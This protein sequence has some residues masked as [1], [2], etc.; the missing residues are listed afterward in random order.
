[1]RSTE[2]LPRELDCVVVGGGAA[3]LSAAVN[4]GRMRR[5]VL[6]VDERD[7]L[8]W[9]H[10]AHNYLG[11]P[12][13]IPA[14]EI[15]RLGWRHAARYGVELL[16][17]HVA[18]AAREGDRF[19]LRIQRLPEGEALGGGPGPSIPRDAEMTR[20]FGEVPKG[21][22]MAVLARTVIL[23][24]GVFGHFPEFP[25]RDECVGVSLFWCIHCDGYES[26]DRVVG[27]VGHDED[28][29]QTA[30]DLLVFT[31]RVTIVAGRPEGFEVPASRLADLA[32]NGIAAHPCGVAE[33]EN[34][35]G[36]MRALVLDDAG[37]TRISVEQVYTVRRTVA[38][39]ELARQLGL[40]LNPIGQ[41]VVTS[42][43]H[44]NVP[45]VYAAG[46]ATS[47]HDHQLSAAVHEGNQAAC[48]ANYYL[49][50]PVQRAPADT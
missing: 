41:I 13:G 19:R 12:D 18:T 33:Y 36:Q 16:L 26:I 35:D 30:L 32:A 48:G 42:E 17:G 45:G 38:A 47:L 8:L 7:L 34:Q 31:A 27:V 14:R 44:T 2:T 3:G 24:T 39:N 29:V 1:M 40:E 9:R 21:G 4:M 46:D 37:R 6:L 50:T 10:V 23:A 20:L 43:Q 22:P 15:R 49:Y 11:F 5:S 25:G 28:A